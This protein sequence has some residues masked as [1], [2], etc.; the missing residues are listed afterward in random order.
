MKVLVFG[1]N[2]FLG[3]SLNEIIDK[4]GV[5]F[6]SVSRFNHK[7]NFN[8]D[9]S[10]YN[11]FSKL[12]IDFFDA[13]VN[14]ATILPGGNFLDTEYLEKIY[15]T[16]ILGSQNICKWIEGQKSIKKIVNCS[17]L[18]VVDKPWPLNLSEN[19]NTY[20]TGAHVLYSSSKLVQELL[21]QTFA[22][23]KKISLSQIRF[24][25]L[26]GAKMNWGG[27]MCNI[28]DQART[29][30]SITLNNASKVTADFLYV[31]D[32]AKIILS[33]L[34][35]NEIGIING[36]SGIETSIL[37]L[38]KIIVNQ[39]DGEIKIE[40]LEDRNFGENRSLIDV[41]KLNKFIDTESFLTLE[42][43]IRKVIQG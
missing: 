32:A 31:D 18:V 34:K 19:H 37:E 14:C 16:N 5:E 28:I 40:N 30:K 8:L 6:Y 20:P 38:A 26:Y 33:A 1:G 12:P 41:S 7:S 10:D 36:A 4:K 25:A 43:G 3:N 29:G 2:G 24:S 27:V 35:N 22:Q 17:T 21:F 42:E 23:S 13:V 39:I 11:Q 9:I 15:K